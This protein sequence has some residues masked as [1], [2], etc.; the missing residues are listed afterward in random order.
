M[1]SLKDLHQLIHSLSKYE[2]IQLKLHFET[3]AGKAKTDYSNSYKCIAKHKNFDRQKLNEALDKLKKR[4]NLSEFN[5]NL[6]HFIVDAL[7]IIHRKKQKKIAL[8]RDIQAI[9]LLFDRALFDQA[10]KA[11]KKIQKNKDFLITENL[12]FLL[13]E[14]EARQILHSPKRNDYDTRLQLMEKQ[15]KIAEQVKK[16]LEVKYLKRKVLKLTASIGTPRTKEQREEYAQLLNHS[17][18]SIQETNIF[19]GALLSDYY[20]IKALLHSV[21]YSNNYK[22]VIEILNEGINKLYQYKQID[23][24]KTLSPYFLL[25]RLR[26]EIAVQS[27]QTEWIENYTHSFKK[28]KPYLQTNQ[29]QLIYQSKLYWAKLLQ[30]LLNP[31]QIDEAIQYVQQN[32]D[33]IMCNQQQKLSAHSYINYIFMARIAFL[34][35]DYALSLDFIETLLEN[36]KSIRLSL[37]PHIYCLQLL[38]HYK[39]NNVEL[40]PYI[41]RN[42]YISILK[43]KQLYAPE[44]ALLSFLRKAVNTLDLKLEIEKLYHRL[45][46]LKKDPY[47]QSFFAHGDYFIWLENEI[48]LQQ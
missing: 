18:F 9:E 27:N 22:N 35:K 19:S 43:T 29:Y 47:H 40:L 4:K 14:L 16:R 36:K 28:L 11:L 38:N 39:L 1:A 45:K 8:H 3:F 24:E 34:A 23:I 25:E 6:Y 20:L 13:L 7:I 12:S 31:E 17:I 21:S 48:G 15:I 30:Y 44:K 32:K 5:T 2:K 10:D 37:L 46:V 33:A 26:M 41:I 42:F